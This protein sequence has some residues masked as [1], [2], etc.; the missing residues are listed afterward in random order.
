MDVIVIETEAFYA[1]L[2]KAMERLQPNEPRLNKWVDGEE[3]MNLLG[4]GKTTLQN[5]RNNGDI[6]FSKVNPKTILYNR[7]SIEQYI[8]N[9]KSETY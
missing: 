2:E 3:A 6:E 9:N 1:L 5:M 7:F 4:I 8:E